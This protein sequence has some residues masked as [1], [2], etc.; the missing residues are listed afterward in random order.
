ME[1]SALWLFVKHY[2]T[3]LVEYAVW[4]FERTCLSWGQV[5]VGVKGGL[6]AAVHS[7]RYHLDCNKDN[8]R[9]VC[10]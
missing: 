7:Y 4:L 3:W 5:G 8:P 9:R 2:N 1:G 10:T 6:E